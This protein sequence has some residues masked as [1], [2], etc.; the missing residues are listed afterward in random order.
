MIGQED[1]LTHSDAG[2]LPVDYFSDWRTRLWTCSCGWSGS[3]TVAVILPSADSVA[4]ECPD[5]HL[6]L[7]QVDRRLSQELLEQAAACGHA[8]AAALLSP[9][10]FGSPYADGSREVRFLTGGESVAF[11]QNGDQFFGVHLDWL[12]A[13]L[14]LDPACGEIDILEG[15]LGIVLD[16]E[17]HEDLDIYGLLGAD[18]TSLCAYDNGGNTGAS[19]SLAGGWLLDS[20]ADDRQLVTWI[21]T[22]P[23]DLRQLALDKLY[24]AMRDWMPGPYERCYVTSP[25]L[26]ADDAEDVANVLDLACEASPVTLNGIELRPEQSDETE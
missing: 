5:C 18:E 9:E 11:F 22:G 17:I 6:A 13:R 7:A 12:L 1:R 23:H 2:P 14:R 15:G 24:E 8:E 26:K 21:G 25:H 19:Y 4:I 16:N 3:N 20:A 10:D